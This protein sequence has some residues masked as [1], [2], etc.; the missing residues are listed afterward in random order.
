MR[1]ATKIFFNALYVIDLNFLKSNTFLK[2]GGKCLNF[3][4]LQGKQK[5]N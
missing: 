1:N 2:K 3:K 5:T 4:A